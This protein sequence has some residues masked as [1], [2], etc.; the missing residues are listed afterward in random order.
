M[1]VCKVLSTGGGGGGGGGG[2]LPPPQKNK[3][4]ELPPKEDCHSTN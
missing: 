1:T 3:N 4:T 2:R